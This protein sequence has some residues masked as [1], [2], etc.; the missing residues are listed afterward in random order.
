MGT[1]DSF[2]AS[3]E[4]REQQIKQQNRKRQRKGKKE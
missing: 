3:E 1:S 4:T 2:D